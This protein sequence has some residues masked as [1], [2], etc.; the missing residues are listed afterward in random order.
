MENR[1]AVFIDF[2]NIKRAVDENFVNERV[3]LKRMLEEIGKV[4]DGRIVMKRA[5]ADWGIFK[6]YRSDLLD[7]A[8][9]PI[10]TFALTYKGKNGAD[11]KIAIDVMD[12]VLRQ[13]DITHVALVTGDSDFTPLV[14]KLRETGRYVIGV[15]VRSNTSTYLAKA[16]DRFC[17]YD[18]LHGA[19]AEDMPERMMPATPMDP[20]A[21]LATALAALGNRAVPGSA[22][23]TTMRKI[24]PMFDETR[25]GHT[26]FLDFLRAHAAIIDLYKPAIGDVSVAPKGR[27]ENAEPLVAPPTSHNG[28]AVP[29]P[30]PMP[31]PESISP[32]P[33]R[34]PIYEST[35]V[36]TTASPSQM[37]AGERLRLWLR[38]NN[39]RYVPSDERQEIIRVMYDLFI[40]PANRDMSLK[41]AKDRLHLWFEEN[42]P[43]VPWESINSTVYHL[44]YTWCFFFDRSDGDEG[45]QLWDRRTTLQSDIHSADELITKSERG[46]ARKLWERDRND[47]DVDALNEWLYD[48]DPK[49]RDYVADI[50]RSVGSSMSNGNGL[51]ANGFPVI[52]VKTLAG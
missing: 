43:S 18:D 4:T 6:D 29:A 13:S 44:F 20:V 47:V 51:G 31:R 45:K 36:Y 7:N 40:D 48:D 3:A 12:V 33:P 34:P 37:T 46:I 35:P 26:S 5:Y 15:G 32:V 10:Q 14:L 52:N 23:K 28:A 8:T 19:T 27:M 30:A 2:E 22:L 11:I 24:D 39:F 16:C 42:R 50:V 25:F 9:D 49:R 1:V 17:Y 21:L 38:D 41:E